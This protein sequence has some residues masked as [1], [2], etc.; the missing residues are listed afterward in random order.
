VKILLDENLDHRFRS[1]LGSHDVFTVTFKG[2]NAL[3]NGDLLKAAKDDG[4][5]VLVTGDK[6]LSYEQNL[7]N[8]KI[9]I[10]CFSAV[11]W[12]IVTTHLA[13]VVAPIESAIPGS[14]QAIDCGS[15]PRRNT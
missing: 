15:F 10:V 8:R 6:S 2:W 1:K 14:F 4:F 5:E 7:T 12:R 13:K 9:A 3:K 11:E